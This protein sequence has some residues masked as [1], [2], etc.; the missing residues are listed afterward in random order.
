MRRRTQFRSNFAIVL[1]V[2]AVAFYQTPGIAQNATTPQPISIWPSTPIELVVTFN[3]PLDPTTANTWIGRTI[4]FQSAPPLESL[5]APPAKPLGSL[6]IANVRLV[7][8]GRTAILATDPHSLAGQYF[9]P[10][11]TA[12]NPSAPDAKHLPYA[13]NLSGVELTWT[14]DN[15]PGEDPRWTG[16]WPQ[17]DSAASAQLLRGAVPSETVAQLTAQP[18]RLVAS[19]LA[20]LPRADVTVGIESNQP[21]EE[22]LFGD[23]QADPVET[24]SDDGWYRTELKIQSKAEPTFLTLT[25]RTAANGPPLAL[26][27]WYRMGAEPIKQPIE[28]SRLLLP[29]A[30]STVTSSTL[31]AIPTPKLTGGNPRAGAKLFSGETGRCAQC[32]LFRG[33]GG[34]VGPDLTTIARKPP[35]E[36]YRSIA[37]PSE[38]IDPLFVTY[39]VATKDGQV[40][41]GVVRAD[42]PENI[43]VMD[44]NSRSTTLPRNRIRQIRP[45]ATSVMPVGLAAALGEA[46]VR[47]VIAYLTSSQPDDKPRQS[48]AGF[49]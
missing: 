43:V 15:A 48:T 35:S 11:P 18:G 8:R 14:D 47:D 1:S 23:Q 24:K 49:R 37:A 38:A 26:R 32:H 4:P 45:S 21:I 16:W 29:W 9:L 19:T 3:A 6:R 33:Q 20:T 28:P 12:S 36:I 41:S 40:L 10:R 22:I 34:R 25:V 42:G 27:S 44:T 2:L 39:T 31:A 30:P 17:L 46:G 7:D 5:A 13:Y